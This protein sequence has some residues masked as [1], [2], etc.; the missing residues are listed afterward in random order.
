MQAI[1]KQMNQCID[2]LENEP[3]NPNLNRTLSSA[4]WAEMFG[5]NFAQ[6][7]PS[8]DDAPPLPRTETYINESDEIIHS[9]PRLASY[10]PP[11]Y[12]PQPTKPSTYLT[13]ME[14]D[15][16]EREQYAQAKANGCMD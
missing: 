3:I 14:M 10:R 13:E 1:V 4:E 2:P 8:L 11:P 5:A 7:G 6:S 9:P 15:A 12:K 16:D